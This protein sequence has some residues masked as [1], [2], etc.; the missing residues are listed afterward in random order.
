MLYDFVIEDM[1][2]G[3]RVNPDIQQ[4]LGYFL[5]EDELSLKAKPLLLII[6]L[7]RNFFQDYRTNKIKFLEEH[8][9]EGEYSI[10]NTIK[11]LKEFRLLLIQ[12]TVKSDNPTKH[13]LGTS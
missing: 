8:C 2:K 1:I 13:I 9:E 4:G 5:A 12:Q 10:K 7:Y 6:I 11:E 3:C